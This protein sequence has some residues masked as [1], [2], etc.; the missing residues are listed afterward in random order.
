MMKYDINRVTLVGNVGEVPRVSECD[1]EAFVANSPLVSIKG[2][3]KPFIHFC[4]RF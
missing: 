3:L 4:E 1:G 2:V